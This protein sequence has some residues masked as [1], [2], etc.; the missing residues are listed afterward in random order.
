MR[1]LFDLFLP[2][3][4]QLLQHHLFKKLSLFH[5][6]PFTHLSKLNRAYLVDLSLGSLFCSIDLIVYPFTNAG[7][8]NG[9]RG[10]ESTL[11]ARDPGDSGLIPGLGRSPGGGN[12]NPLHYS[13]L[14]NPVEREAWWGD[15]G[16]HGLARVGH[17]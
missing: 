3:V 12:G 11:N 17:D 10:K 15:R 8:P 1:F 13:C 5:R 14:E 4:D 7:F 9:S 16:V 6:I 2:I